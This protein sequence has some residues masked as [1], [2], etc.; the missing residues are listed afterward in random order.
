MQAD[1]RDSGV[2]GQLTYSVVYQYDRDHVFEVKA[3]PTNPSIAI[4]YSL[5]SFNRES[6]SY[7]GAVTYRGTV[8]LKV[9]FVK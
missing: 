1:D 7:Y 5:V 8:T 3:H 9:K 6:A 2:N 4:L